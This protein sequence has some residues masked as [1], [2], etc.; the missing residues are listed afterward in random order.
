VDFIVRKAGEPFLLYLPHTFP[1]VSAACL[2]E[3]EGLVDGRPLWR[4]LRRAGRQCRPGDGGG[5]AGR[6]CRQQHRRRDE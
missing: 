5:G 6:Y 4:R 1:Y 2:R 3:A